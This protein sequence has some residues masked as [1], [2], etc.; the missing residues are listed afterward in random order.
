MTT[1]GAHDL[2]PF[3]RSAILALN[4]LEAAGARRPSFGPDP[5]ARWKAFRGEL[6]D[7]DRI[8]LLL[9]NAAATA[10]AA[11][12]P[13]VILAIPG[14]AEDEPFG[15][16]WTGPDHALAATL[17]RLAAQPPAAALPEVLS[18]VV[19]AWGLAPA[20]LAKDR[21]ASIAP[22]S[23]IVAAGAGAVLA[24]AER[25]QAGR[26]FDLSEQLLLI[27]GV[28]GER[29]LFGIAAALLG[30]AG[31]PRML[32]LNAV[33]DTARASGF[34]RADLLLVSDDAEPGARAA[35]E[36]ISKELGG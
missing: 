5:D 22:Q 15:P 8:D 26:G 1:T 17:L 30:S 6:R 13:R 10:P 9:R 25:F 20:A 35:A 23:R 3:Y 18:Q 21:T 36:R 31:V 32:A 34:T 14:L 28:P 19:R 4:A 7:A 29:Q 16:D 11:F 33:A 27:T 24:L 2:E 12:A